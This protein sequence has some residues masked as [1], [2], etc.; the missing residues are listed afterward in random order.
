MLN[1]YSP[2]T[3]YDS[4]F[5]YLK[6][7]RLYHTAAFVAELVNV[8][9]AAKVRQVDAHAFGHVYLLIHFTSQNG[10]ENLDRITLVVIFLKV[11]VNN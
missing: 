5:R 3:T 9:A 11:K 2:S 4:L 7:T 10:I 1:G 8:N 6:L